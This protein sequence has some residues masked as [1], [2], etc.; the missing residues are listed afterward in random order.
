MLNGAF[1]LY[2]IC[3]FTNRKALSALIREYKEKYGDAAFAEKEDDLL[4]QINSK[5][6]SKDA[7]P[8][9]WE[10]VRAD[11]ASSG[12][13]FKWKE[14]SVEDLARVMRRRV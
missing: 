8:T 4:R 3:N 14:Q 1:L 2:R 5:L 9:V 7:M 6:G 13:W 11:G 10:D 12:A